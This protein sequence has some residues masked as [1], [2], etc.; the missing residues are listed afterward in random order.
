MNKKINSVFEETGKKAFG[1]FLDN[2]VMCE[3]ERGV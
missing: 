3:C 1:N 2:W